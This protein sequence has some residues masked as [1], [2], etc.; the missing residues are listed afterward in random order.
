MNRVANYEEVANKLVE[1][2]EQETPAIVA[3]NEYQFYQLCK[4]MKRINNNIYTETMNV[5]RI[6]LFMIF[7]MFQLR[8][9]LLLI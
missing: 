6:V 3:V 1:C 8:E 7:L 9:S 5:K 2:Y 4:I